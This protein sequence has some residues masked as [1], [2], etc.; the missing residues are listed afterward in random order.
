MITTF[1]KYKKELQATKKDFSFLFPL[2]IDYFKFNLELTSNSESYSIISD[3]Y[4]EALSNNELNKKVLEY[5]ENI[6]KED[7]E[8]LNKEEIKS[9]IWI[10][11]FGLEKLPDIE[12]IFDWEV[13]DTN[14]YINFHLKDP[15][16][17]YPEVNFIHRIRDLSNVSI[18]DLLSVLEED[19]YDYATY[20]V[21]NY[22]WDLRGE[23]L[24]YFENF[25][26][27]R[28]LSLKKDL[29]INE[30]IQKL[31]KI[32][33]QLKLILLDIDLYNSIDISKHELKIRKNSLLNKRKKDLKAIP[34][35]YRTLSAI[36]RKIQELKEL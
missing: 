24:D 31:K 34:L 6:S 11:Y 17:D 29:K 28:I 4:S 35:K 13:I 23:Y 1:Q 18:N 22:N 2:K 12:F 21:G 14:T 5:L 27:P 30:K 19:I 10:Y 36:D 8:Y 26:K 3:I 9:L 33:A 25:L 32:R 7:L 16:Y 20:S 15:L